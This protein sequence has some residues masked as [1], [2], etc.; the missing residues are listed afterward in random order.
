MGK[1]TLHFALFGNNDEDRPPKHAEGQPIDTQP[2]VTQP[3]G[4]KE[5]SVAPF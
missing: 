4:K 3:R 1:R 2:T 5:K